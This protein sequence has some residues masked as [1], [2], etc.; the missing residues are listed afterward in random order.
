[1]SRFTFETPPPVDK[2]R[3]F[4]LFAYIGWKTTNS[5]T[6]TGISDASQEVY[7]QLYTRASLIY[8]KPLRC[9]PHGVPFTPIPDSPLRLHGPR[10]GTDP[11]AHTCLPC[12]T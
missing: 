1:M 3:K 10:V 9:P 8:P 11:W 12:R 7:H 4:E 2:N 5:R 6:R